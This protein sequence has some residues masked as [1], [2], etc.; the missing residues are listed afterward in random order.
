M[1]G[2]WHLLRCEMCGR[3]TFVAPGEAAA[4]RAMPYLTVT[5]DECVESCLRDP[6]YFERKRL[7]VLRERAALH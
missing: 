7:H 3:S 4:L 1:I 6:I 2:V 5:C